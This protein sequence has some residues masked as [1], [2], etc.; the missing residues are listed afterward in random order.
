MTWSVV[1]T[2]AW[3][4][5]A[6]ESEGSSTG[7]RSSGRGHDRQLYDGDV[8]VRERTHASERG[9]GNRGP[10]AGGL[11]VAGVGEQ[12][13]HPGRQR[14]HLTAGDVLAEHVAERPVELGAQLLQ[15]LDDVVGKRL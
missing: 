15:P 7:G 9:P 12:R 13:V 14:A 11:R 2:A 3:K 6:P 5:A 4:S 10:V 1:G 8:R